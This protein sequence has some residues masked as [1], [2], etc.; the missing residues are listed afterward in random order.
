M[1]NI[2]VRAKLLSGDYQTV[3]VPVKHTVDQVKV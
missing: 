3:E 1:A 2:K